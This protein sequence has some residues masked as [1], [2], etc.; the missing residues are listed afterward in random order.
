MI[1]ETR[2]LHF[3]MALS[4]PWTSCL[5]KLPN[6]HFRFPFVAQKRRL[7]KLPII[8]FSRQQEVNHFLPLTPSVKSISVNV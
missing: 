5:L 4:L 3:Q 7:L 2:S 8:F 1:A 6:V